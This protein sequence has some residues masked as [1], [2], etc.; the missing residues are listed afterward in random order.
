MLANTFRGNLVD[1]SLAGIA[2]IAVKGSPHCE[3]ICGIARNS[4]G[5]R[6][7]DLKYAP[8]FR[9]GRAKYAYGHVW[10]F[11]AMAATKVPVVGFEVRLVTLLLRS[12][13]QTHRSIVSRL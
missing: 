8:P 10:Q 11:G 1:F 3:T 6:R 4:A 7:S 9:P 13:G 2:T 5:R 12:E